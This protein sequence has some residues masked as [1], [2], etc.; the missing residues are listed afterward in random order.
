MVKASI[1]SFNYASGAGKARG[2]TFR[3]A[4]VSHEPAWHCR[5]RLMKKS[6]CDSWTDADILIMNPNLPLEMF[7]PPE[8]ELAHIN[9]L[10][11]NDRHGLNNGVFF[12]RINNWALKFFTAI[13]SFH[14]FRP[15]VQLKYTEQSAMEEMTKEVSS[16]LLSNSLRHRL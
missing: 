14:H 2:T 10:V 16:P 4:A 15:E 1:S 9:L 12:I 8:P 3:V 7:I 11:T 13:L 6:Y 5:I